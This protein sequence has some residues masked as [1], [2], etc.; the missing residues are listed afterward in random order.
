MFGKNKRAMNSNIKSF[1]C[2]EPR[3]AWANHLAFAI[4]VHWMRQNAFL[5][6]PQKIVCSHSSDLSASQQVFFSCLE[7]SSKCFLKSE[8][9]PRI[10][11]HWPHAVSAFRCALT[12]PSKAGQIS[13]L[14]CRLLPPFRFSMIMKPGDLS[15]VLKLCI[16]SGLNNFPACCSAME[17]TNNDQQQF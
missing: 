16:N 8:M 9:L 17:V 7:T 2:Q 11:F 6:N 14:E 3:T 1:K 13:L 4:R 15:R 10:L 5:V 12:H